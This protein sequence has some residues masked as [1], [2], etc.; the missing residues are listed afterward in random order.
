MSETADRTLHDLSPG[1]SGI[2]LSVGS[3]SGAVKR[4]LVDM[5]LYARDEC[6]SEKDRAVR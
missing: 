1:Q 4:R 5:G 2:I 3:H 6:Y